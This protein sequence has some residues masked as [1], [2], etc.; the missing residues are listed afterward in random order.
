MH[1]LH[2]VQRKDGSFLVVAVCNPGC[3][4]DMMNGISRGLRAALTDKDV[5]IVVPYTTV[6][7]V[8]QSS[9]WQSLRAWW[10]ARRLKEVKENP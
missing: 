6:L 9:L 1:K 7:V 8:A 3:P 5:V 2:I 10:A 4:S